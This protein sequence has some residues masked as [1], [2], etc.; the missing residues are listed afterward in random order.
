MKCGSGQYIT[1]KGE[2]I[3]LSENS[4]NYRVIL[5]TYNHDFLLGLASFISFV[6]LTFLKMPNKMSSAPPRF[7]V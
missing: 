2:V 7:F 3:Q 6:Q 1:R 5:I 4:L